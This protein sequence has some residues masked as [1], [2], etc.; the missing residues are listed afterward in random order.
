VTLFPIVTTDSPSRSTKVVKV[1]TKENLINSNVRLLNAD[2]A[3]VRTT[4]R[5]KEANPQVKT[6]TQPTTKRLR[7]K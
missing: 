5:A 6:A 3:S 1:L 7:M 4:L 2:P